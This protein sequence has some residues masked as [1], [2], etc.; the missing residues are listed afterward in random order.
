MVNNG[1]NNV[2]K[3]ISCMGYE[4]VLRNPKFAQGK[5]IVYELIEN[6]NSDLASAYLEQYK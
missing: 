4:H 1:Q 2:M 3:T 6:D 5:E